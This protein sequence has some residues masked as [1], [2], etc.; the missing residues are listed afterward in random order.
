MTIEYE[1]YCLN[2][3]NQDDDLNTIFRILSTGE[4]KCI[5]CNEIRTTVKLNLSKYMEK[6]Q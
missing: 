3:K 4:V 1:L 2:C 6:K 5:K